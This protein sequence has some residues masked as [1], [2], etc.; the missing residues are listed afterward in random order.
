MASVAK[1]VLFSQ[2]NSTT[3]DFSFSK[4]KNKL[5]NIKHFTSEE[6]IPKECMKSHEVN[7][8]F[9]IFHLSLQINLWQ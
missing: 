8:N 4:L 1:L 7:G 5:F 9:H 6:I 3:N 2:R